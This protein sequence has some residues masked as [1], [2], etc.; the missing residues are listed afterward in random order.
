MGYPNTCETLDADWPYSFTQKSNVLFC[1]QRYNHFSPS[2]NCSCLPSSVKHGNAS[3]SSLQT[4]L[5]GSLPS[6]STADYPLIHRFRQTTRPLGFQKTQKEGFKRP[7]DFCDHT[8]EK[9]ELT[10]SDFKVIWCLIGGFCWTTETLSRSLGWF[11]GPGVR[12]RLRS[13]RI[14]GCVPFGGTGGDVPRDHHCPHMCFPHLSFFVEKYFRIRESC[15]G[16]ATC[17][18]MSPW[19]S[20]KP[21]YSEPRRHPLPFPASNTTR[22]TPFHFN[23]VPFTGATPQW[24]HPDN[25]QLCMFLSC[26]RY[27]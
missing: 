9:D 27:P 21:D 4:R 26:H 14:S 15:G 3:R 25:A 8:D 17:F 24:L 12:R 18:A 1:S 19:A 13:S 10:P 22:S 23:S 11:E 7:T 16:K 5:F 6:T 20:N 2:D